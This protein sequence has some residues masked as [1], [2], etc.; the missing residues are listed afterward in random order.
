V[1]TVFEVVGG[2]G[3]VDEGGTP[4]TIQWPCEKDDPQLSL[5]IRGK[6]LRSAGSG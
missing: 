4:V 1:L 3:V 6:D 2:A 5:P